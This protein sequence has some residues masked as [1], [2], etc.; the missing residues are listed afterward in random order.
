MEG[1]LVVFLW[2]AYAAGIAMVARVGGRCGWSALVICLVF[3]P[4]LGAIV[5]LMLPVER[6][7]RSGPEGR[8]Q[9][10]KVE[11]VRP[12]PP[13]PDE[14]TPQRSYG[15]RMAAAKRAVAAREKRLKQRK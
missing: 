12:L 10:N 14:G 2:V 5:V 11:P 4:L 1:E 13:P 15:E 9:R 7:V 6:E 3:S 8:A